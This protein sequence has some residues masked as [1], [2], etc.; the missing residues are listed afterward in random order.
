MPDIGLSLLGGGCAAAYQVGLPTCLLARGKKPKKIQ[1]VS[2]G[3]I[4]AAKLV[5]KWNPDDLNKVWLK[6]EENGPEYVFQ[7]HLLTTLLK[8]L[9]FCYA[10]EGL[11]NIIRENIDMN[12]VLASDIELEV[13]V[14][15]RKERRTEIFANKPLSG[16]DAEGSGKKD[17]IRHVVTDPEI[18][19]RAVLASASLSGLF[20]SVQIFPGGHYYSDGCWMELETFADSCDVIFL[21]NNDQVTISD[22][23]D[24]GRT[25]KVFRQLFSSFRHTLD[26]L[27]DVKIKLFQEQHK[28]FNTKIDS[29]I[30]LLKRLLRKVTDSAKHLVVLSPF[31]D[32]K[33]LQLDKFSK[34]NADITKAI[35]QSIGQAQ[36]TLDELNL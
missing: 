9:D 28:D 17:I 26:E 21:L 30:D 1:G 20:P 15:N 2:A 4:N 11:E 36:K 24:D 33:S 27:V 3:A 7:S 8:K 35:T 34:S 22:D 23:A 32:I 14:W 10:R 16:F 13:V 5:E 6:F 19:H 29:P 31:Y 18:M 12:A 25:R